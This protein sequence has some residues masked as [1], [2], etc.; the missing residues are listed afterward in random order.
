M[1]SVCLY[2]SEI[3][4]ITRDNKYQ[5]LKDLLL[6][7]W[8]RYNNE[9]FVEAVNNIQKDSDVQFVQQET[10]IQ[11]LKRIAEN[12]NI[13]IK[14]ELK[15]CRATT[16]ATELV[17]K[18]SELLKKA[19]NLSKEDQKIFKKSVSNYTN[20]TFGINNEDSAINLFA[21]Q[22]NK[23]IE[24]DGIFR[25][26]KIFDNWY[27]GGKIDGMTSDKEIVEIKNRIYKLFYKLRDYEKVQ[28]MTYMYINKMDNAYL[29][30]CFSKNNNKELNTI[31]VPFDKEYFDN[32]VLK[33]I[34][35]FK[36]FYCDFLENVDLKTVLLFGDEEMA[37][38]TILSIF[39][40]Y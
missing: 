32:H 1:T 23:K 26:K 14:E 18:Q 15:K 22:F 10:D 29:V 5:K 7:I 20:T 30:E 4:I 28:I 9:D 31:E 34:E 40:K 37:E 36:N 2:A 19:E 6:K 38:E 17:K 16:N 12:N 8:Q 21:K 35:K 39:N 3:A 27:I 13:D 24:S 25:K 33:N 11:C